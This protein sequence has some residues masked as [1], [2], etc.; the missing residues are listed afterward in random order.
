MCDVLNVPTSSFYEWRDR[1]PSKRQEEDVELSQKI[2]MVFDESDSTYGYL[3][4]WKEFLKQGVSCGK[5]RIGRLMRANGWYVRVR[6]RVK[7]TTKSNP[8][9]QKMA[10]LLNQ[11]FKATRM[12]EKWTSDITYIRTGEGW[13]YLAVVLD[14][15]SRRVVGWAMDKCMEADLVTN[16]L[17]MAIEQRDISAD[18]LAHS[19]QGSQYTGHIYQNLL[20]AND[21]TV[22]MSRRGNCYDNA[23][24]ESFFGTLKTE[25]VHRRHYASRQDAMLDIFTYIEGWYNT[26]RSH[27]TLGYLSPAEFEQKFGAI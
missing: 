6:R 24:T 25:R 8:A 5:H 22:S 9:H 23:V 15:F 19:D 7:T 4:I 27:S 1:L 18:L 17:K 12:N 26:H 2:K 11:N 14:L 13:L 10:N 20:Q 16:A 3:R 21:I